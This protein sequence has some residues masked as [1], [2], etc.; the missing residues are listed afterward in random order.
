MAQMGGRED[1]DEVA[2]RSVLD[3]FHDDLINLLN[4]SEV[5]HKID[6]L[7]E[8]DIS[9][10]IYVTRNE[11]D[12]HGNKLFLEILN[13]SSSEAQILFIQ[14][15]LDSKTPIHDDLI[16]NL[17]KFKGLCAKL[18]GIES[19]TVAGHVHVTPQLAQVSMLRD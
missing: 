3:G 13:K 18:T 2:L 12:K 19:P 1:D 8:S 17:L 6:G 9:D 16:S 11:G 7:S 10:I 14:Y 15:L 5:I 4:P